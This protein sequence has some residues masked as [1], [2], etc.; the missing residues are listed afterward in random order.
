[1]STSAE[2]GGRGAGRHRG[3]PA[4]PPNY[5]LV[6]STPPDTVVLSLDA[7]LNLSASVRLGAILTDLIVGQGNLTV[8]VDLRGL[9]RVDPA[10]LEVFGAAAGAVEARGGTL[11][12]RGLPSGF[13][14]ALTKAGLGRLVS[15]GPTR[16]RTPILVP[17]GPSCSN[18]HPAGSASRHLSPGRPE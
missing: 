1:L 7:E 11:T 13:V 5:W 12:L 8:A 16:H 2:P 15:S 4:T 9:G 17:P 3:S 18:L 10:A 14:G 6:L